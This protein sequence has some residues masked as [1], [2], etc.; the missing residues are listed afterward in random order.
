MQW[1]PRILVAISLSIVWC[2]HGIVDKHG[3]NAQELLVCDAAKANPENQD[4]FCMDRNQDGFLQHQE[5]PVEAVRFVEEKIL[6]SDL[7]RNADPDDQTFQLSELVR[8]AAA[9]ANANPSPLPIETGDSDRIRDYATTLINVCDQNRDGVLSRQESQNLSST[10]KR[11]DYDRDG[12]IST[13]ELTVWMQTIN[14]SGAQILSQTPSPFD[15]P[16][17]FVEIDANVDGQIQMHEFARNWTEAELKKFNGK[18]ANR[19]AI[20]TLQEWLQHQVE[21]ETS[22]KDH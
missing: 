11:K 9:V 8:T 14:S 2:A 19:D 20:I 13:A 10:W 4:L 5:I 16:V 17:E 7:A 1:R 21:N 12:N 3:S 15:A 6:E 22:T 18:D